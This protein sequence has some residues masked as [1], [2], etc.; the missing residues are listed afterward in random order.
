MN[1]ISIVLLIVASLC[2]RVD[3]RRREPDLSGIWVPITFE[4]SP[5][6]AALRL[7]TQGEDEVDVASLQYSAR[8]RQYDWL[9]WRFRKRWGPRYGPEGASQPLAKRQWDGATF[10]TARGFAIPPSALALYS[11]SQSD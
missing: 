9:P 4:Y 10:I 7:I 6:E 1:R 5:S 3:G 8:V 11:L 2:G